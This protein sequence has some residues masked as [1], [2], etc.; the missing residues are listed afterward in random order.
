MLLFRE[1]VRH[2]AAWLFLRMRRLFM[3]SWPRREFWRCLLVIDRAEEAVPVAEALWAGGITVVE[4]P[5]RSPEAWAALRLI[6]RA[7]PDMMIGGGTLLT[8]E[9]VKQAWEVGADFGVAPGMNPRVVEAASAISLPFMPGV[10][11][12]T[13]IDRAVEYGCSWLKFF[14]CEPSGGLPYLRVIAA[15]FA[16]LGLQYLPLGGITLENMAEY[17]QEP[18]VGAVGGSWLAS[19]E[20]IRQRDWAAITEAARQACAVRETVA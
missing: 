11:T 17:L 9:Q 10:C 14:P 16:H 4:L 6:R 19:R 5:L 12:P 3:K 20:M 1:E 18:C 2:A 13:D 8:P 15:P 7:C